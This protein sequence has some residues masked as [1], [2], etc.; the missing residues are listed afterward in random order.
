MQDLCLDIQGLGDGLVDLIP[1]Q[2]LVGRDMECMP[3]RLVI[4]QQAYEPLCKVVCV[5]HY[6]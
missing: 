4:A 2:H 5:C 6:P 1:R 3:Q